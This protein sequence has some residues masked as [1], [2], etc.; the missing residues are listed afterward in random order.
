MPLRRRTLSSLL[1]SA[2]LWWAASRRPRSAAAM[3]TASRL[4]GSRN[5]AEA[6]RGPRWKQSCGTERLIAPLDRRFSALW[7]RGLKARRTVLLGAALDEERF[8]V[9]V[10]LPS[11]PGVILLRHIDDGLRA[12]HAIRPEMSTGSTTR[13]VSPFRREELAMP[14]GSSVRCRTGYLR[15]LAGSNTAANFTQALKTVA[16]NRSDRA[17]DVSTLSSSA[18]GAARR[19]AE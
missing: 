1:V 10:S 4:S 14:A 12:S 7:A 18:L 16:N 3:S 8:L 5:G 13:R 17:A 6:V 2:S 15:R 19:T 9:G 11:E